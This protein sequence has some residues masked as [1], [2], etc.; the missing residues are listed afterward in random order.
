MRLQRRT[1]PEQRYLAQFDISDHSIRIQLRWAINIYH[2]V[3]PIPAVGP[4]LITF[5]E[6]T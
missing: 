1:L 2:I 5:A 6:T 4:T 3:G